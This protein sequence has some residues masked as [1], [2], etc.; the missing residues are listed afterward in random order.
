MACSRKRGPIW[1]A[2]PPCLDLSQFCLMRLWLTWLMP[3]SHLIW[4]P[5]LKWHLLTPLLLHHRWLGSIGQA[6]D[7]TMGKP[8]KQPPPRAT[9][10]SSCCKMLKEDMIQRSGGLP[11]SEPAGFNSPPKSDSTSSPQHSLHGSH[12]CSLDGPLSQPQPS[13]TAGPGQR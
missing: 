3:P 10:S 2:P 5:P 4:T 1:A 7:S 9:T 12:C 11:C 8:Y 13:G 6:R